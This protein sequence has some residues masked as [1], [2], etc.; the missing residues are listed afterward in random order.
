[1]PGAVCAHENGRTTLTFSRAL[2]ARSA[3]QRAILPGRAQQLIFAHG[4]EGQWTAGYHG[5]NRGGVMLDFAG[6]EPGALEAAGRGLSAPLVLHMV[7]PLSGKSLYKG[8]PL[9]GIYLRD[10]PLGD[11]PLYFLRNSPL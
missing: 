1:M 7:L 3:S 10:F 5:G 6:A 4:E 8:F 11:F 2:A 9:E